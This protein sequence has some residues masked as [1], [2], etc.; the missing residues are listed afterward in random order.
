MRRSN[1]LRCRSRQDRSGPGGAVRQPGPARARGRHRRDARR[2]RQPRRGPP[3][4]EDGLAER[5]RAAVAAG[6]LGATTEALAAVAASNV[7]VVVVPLLVDADGAPAFGALDEATVAIG[8]GPRPGSAV[9]YE[10]TVPVTTTCRRFAPM[11]AREPGWCAERRCTWRSAPSA[12]TLGRVFADLRRYPKLVGGLDGPSTAAAVAFYQRAL[13]FDPARPRPAERCLGPWLGGGGGAGQ[14]RRD[15]VPR[16]QYRVRQRARRV[17]RTLPHRCVQGDRGVEQ[18]TVQPHPPPRIAVGGHCIP[19]YRACCWPTTR[20][21]WLPGCRSAANESVPA[22]CVAR[23]G[24]M[25]GGLEGQ[26]V[27]VLA[28]PTVGSSRRPRSRASFPGREARVGGGDPARARSAL[29]RRRTTSPLGFTP[30]HL[31]AACDGA[32]WRRT[33]RSTDARP[34]RSARRTRPARRSTHHLRGLVARFIGAT[35]GVGD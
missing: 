16:H 9:I 8:R 17:R 7:I 14:A 20:V 25:L 4:G 5:V 11:L 34:A 35:I 28:P 6:L 30:Y 22:R 3:S 13:E 21:R 1:R 26:R 31:G 23:L 32:S 12:C 10:T 2:R 33:T 24:A 29:Q 15:D 19:V 27:V 18:P